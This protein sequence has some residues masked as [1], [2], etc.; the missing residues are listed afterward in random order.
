MRGKIGSVRLDANLGPPWHSEFETDSVYRP[1][2]IFPY[3]C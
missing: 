3:T 2:S 1:E